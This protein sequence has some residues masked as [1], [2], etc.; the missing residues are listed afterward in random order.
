LV[1]NDI[2]PVVRIYDDHQAPDRNMFIV[3]NPDNIAELISHFGDMKPLVEV[4]NEL[5][6]PVE[7]NPTYVHLLDWHND[8]IVNRVANSILE[9]IKAV[10]NLGG[11]PAFPAFA[12]T[13]R[14]AV[15]QQYSGYMWGTKVF[16]RMVQVEP[17]FIYEHLSSGRL[18]LSDHS[19]AMARPF[20]FNPYR[21]DG[22]IDDMC[23][24]GFEPLAD[25]I[26]AMT[27]IVPT[28]ILTEGGVFSPVHLAQIGW[29]DCVRNG[30]VYYEGTEQKFY[31]DTIWGDRVVEAFQFLK[32]PA[33][34][35]HFRDVG[36]EWDGAGWYDKN[37]NPRS[38]ITALRG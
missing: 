19:A 18:W 24:R 37:W 23:L 20:S 15:H 33:M 14:N 34:F 1:A 25:Y 7:W 3:H 28:I 4:A 12:H 11:W 6:L 22:R 5:N 13:D 16:K 32:L 38:P 27:G 29:D 21:P 17:D 8:D 30:V 9:D 2:Q 10:I 26:E 35:W 36:N 31:D